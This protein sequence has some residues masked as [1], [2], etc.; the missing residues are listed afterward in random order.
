MSV[1]SHKVAALKGTLL[2]PGDKSISHRALIF[3]SQGNGASEIHGLLESEDV[4]HTA[5]A[6]QSM[7]VNITK[8]KGKNKATIWRIDGVG[9]GGLTEPNDVLYMGN[10]GTGA[11]LM[12][13]LVSSYPFTSFFNGDESLRKRPMSRVTIPL[14][15]SGAQ[16]LSH[17]GEKLPLSVTGIREALPINYTLP[18]A[19]AQVKSAILLAALNI[20]GKTT[21]VEPIATRDHT[22]RM[23]KYLGVE[24]ESGEHSITLKG[25]PELKAFDLTVPGDPSSA[26]FPIVAALITKGSDITLPNICINPLRIGLYVTLLEM[27][28]DIE[29][30]NKTEVAGELV[31][32]IRVRSSKLKGIKVPASRAPSMIDEYPILA[33]AAA[34][35]EGDTIMEG[36]EELRVKESDRLAAVAAGLEANGV[37]HKIE[38][39]TL[40]VTGG[41][42]TGGGLV[43]THFDHRIAMSFLI[44][45][46]V[47]KKP[48]GVDDVSMI[49]TSFPNFM[50]L[51]AGIG[52]EFKKA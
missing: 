41:K 30:K 50:E 25:Q 13:G 45:G 46:M 49:N 32:D 42:A 18:V 20:A 39:D 11:R 6:L 22:E 17:T 47:A 52:A 43:E 21:V 35:A 19:S 40:T 1:T 37:T 34:M 44:L 3:G 38:G 29:F 16:F 9:T 10:S 7:G 51:M 15:Q 8:T 31:A 24:V 27:G 4:I 28:A 14:A 23:L 26:A 12:M 48:V 33:I 36:L 2:V 5:Q